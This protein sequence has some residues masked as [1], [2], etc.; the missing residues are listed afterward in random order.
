MFELLKPLFPDRERSKCLMADDVNI[1]N[2]IKEETSYT[3][4]TIE[5]LLK[6]KI[7]KQ[8]QTKTKSRKKNRTKNLKLNHTC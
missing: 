2:E 4:Q 1:C 3:K 5:N 8:N 7:N 6:T